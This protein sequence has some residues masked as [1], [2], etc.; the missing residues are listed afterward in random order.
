MLSNSVFKIYRLNNLF[1]IAYSDGIIKKS[2]VEY[3]QS[4]K[5]EWGIDDEFYRYLESKASDLELKIPDSE[6]QREECLIDALEL[7]FCDG[8]F[9][10]EEY[11]MCLEVAK[12]LSFSQ[13]NFCLIVKLCIGTEKFLKIL[14]EDERSDFISFIYTSKN[15]CSEDQQHIE[16]DLKKEMVNERKA[17]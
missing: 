13:L 2:E 4:K 10:R 7:S 8:D 11:L 6:Q 17:S 5:E 9:A 14:N 12:S 1:A 15:G 3:I 16:I